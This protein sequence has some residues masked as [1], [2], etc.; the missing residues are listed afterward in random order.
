MTYVLIIVT[1][2]YGGSAVHTQE[3]S[4]KENCELA[5]TVTSKV[6]EELRGRG[7]VSTMCTPR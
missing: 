4:S 6:S 3:F 1:Y 7:A 5:R 2:V